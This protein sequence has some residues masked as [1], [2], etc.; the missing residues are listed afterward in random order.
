MVRCNVLTCSKSWQATAQWQKKRKRQELTTATDIAQKIQSGWWSVESVLREMESTVEGFGYLVGLRRE[1]KC[2]G[3]MDDESGESTEE[4]DVTSVG[5]GES[6][7]ERLGCWSRKL[8]AETRWGRLKRTTSYTRDDVGGRA[9]VTRWKAS[10]ARRLNRDEFM[11]IQ[12]LGGCRSLVCKWQ[13]LV[14]DAFS[15]FF[16]QN[17]CL[18][19]LITISLNNDGWLWTSVPPINGTGIS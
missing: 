17:I 4:D 16:V 1:W 10:V 7:M 11:Q 8:I 3:V 5:R 13:E 12:R 2:E 9:T 6:E 15:Y 18:C 19:V 14:L